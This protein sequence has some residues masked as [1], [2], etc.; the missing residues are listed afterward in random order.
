MTETVR[1]TSPHSFPPSCYRPREYRARSAFHRNLYPSI[2]THVL[3]ILFCYE[4]LVDRQVRLYLWFSMQLN[5]RIHGK[6]N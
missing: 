1:W 6:D 3:M 4:G 5:L 2:F